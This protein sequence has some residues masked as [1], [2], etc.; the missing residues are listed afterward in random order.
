[1]ADFTIDGV[2]YKSGLF[3][4]KRQIHVMKRLLPAFTALSGVAGE[5]GA[6]AFPPPLAADAE[7]AL[8]DEDRA[9]VAAAH[10]VAMSHLALILAPVTERLAALSD[11]DVDFILDN[12]YEVTERQAVNAETWTPLT[13]SGDKADRKFATRLQVAWHVV[14][15]NFADMFA[16]FGVDIQ[17]LVSKAGA[18]R[19]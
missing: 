9:T 13:K 1:M 3:D 7:A 5:I 6:I 19:G 12:C 14:G 18:A 17:G 8:S 4:G 16:S 10:Q 15:E 11:A 2:P